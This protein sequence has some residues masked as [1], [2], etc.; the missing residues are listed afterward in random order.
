[1]IETFNAP[2]QFFKGN[3]H[4]HSTRSDGHMS[5]ARVCAFYRD[6][7][8]DFVCVSDHFIDT[9][10]FPV[11]DTSDFRTDDFTTLCGAEI[12]SG[13]TEAGDIWHILA[14]G[15]PLDF[16]HTD[17]EESGPALAQRALDAG[18]F[19]ALPHPEWYGL[20]IRDAESMPEGIHAVEMFNAVCDA[21]GREGGG[22]LLDQ[23]MTTGR[24]LGAIAVDDAHYY[25]GDAGLGWT[26]VK[27]AERT[28]DA[29]LAALKAGQ[30]YSSTGPE[31]RHVER[32][33]THLFVECS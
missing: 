15:L 20:S 21:M 1:M 26:M 12:H 8:Y 2:G 3:L 4:C 6:A 19:V 13:Q 7:G 24:T 9:Y 30:F 18:A 10:N 5:P 17:P 32:N 25:R 27:A 16:A 11:T 14:V 31:I 23:M 28:P 29:L 22:Y 33:E